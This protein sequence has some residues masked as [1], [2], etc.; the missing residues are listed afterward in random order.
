MRNVVL[1]LAFS[2]VALPALAWDGIDSAS[3]ESVSIE[4][5]NLVRSGQDIKFY[6]VA[7]GETRTATVE[8]VTT[9]GSGADVEIYDHDSGETRTL[10]ME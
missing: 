6:D 1:L 7:K 4:R 9:S 2:I 5:G 8:S 10:E 3:G